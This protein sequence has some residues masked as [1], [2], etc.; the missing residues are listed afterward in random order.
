MTAISRIV[1]GSLAA[2]VTIGV[3]LLGQLCAVPIFLHVW[4]KSIF[5]RWL[6]LQTI[7]AL[8][9]IPDIAHQSYLGG[10]LYKAGSDDR[11]QITKLFS[12]GALAAI[13]VSIVEFL[14]IVILVVSGQIKWLFGSQ[15]A[16]DLGI[17]WPEIVFVIGHSALWCTLGSIG[18]IAVRVVSVFGYFPRMAW[19]GAALA[20]ATLVV[21]L[22]IAL[23]GGGLLEVV[24][25]YLVTMAIVQ[26]VL[27]T[28]LRRIF[29]K[30]GIE[31]KHDTL[32]E[33]LRRYGTSLL[34]AAQNLCDIARQQGA[35]L[36]L[37]PLTG[38][39]AVADFATMRT[40]ANVALQG[41]STVTNPLMPE[42]MRVLRLRD[43]ERVEGAFG[44]IW[45]LLLLGMAPA[46]V[47]IQAFIEPAFL[48]WTN[49]TIAYDP[50]LFAEFSLAVLL[51]AIFQPAQAVV[52]GNNLVRPQIFMGITSCIVAVVGMM[53]LTP[54]FGLNGAAAALCLAELVVGLCVTAACLRW[55]S[56][57]G[58]RWPWSS[59]GWVC[60]G[61]GVAIIGCFGIC[62]RP[63]ASGW[64]AIFA[65]LLIC[66]TAF[67]YWSSLPPLARARSLSLVQRAIPKKR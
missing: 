46:V 63:D 2:W 18:G 5:A 6:L 45:L 20:A 12:S 29:R 48:R 3:S 60:L 28:D 16:V 35:R 33:G 66:L 64:I 17:G 43:Q 57:A 4:D 11:A 36:I 37:A 10:E 32:R 44:S 59:F 30:L 25:G 9:Q 40:G 7:V 53:A 41:L 26:S 51:C 47:M 50:W 56:Q 38:T 24:I 52:R 49:F 23:L 67:G 19:W 8:F 58:L 1:S 65:T 39:A 54:R 31:F 22:A 27:C 14:L 61:V 62:I 42:L 34:L 15:E 13:C 21:T 55:M